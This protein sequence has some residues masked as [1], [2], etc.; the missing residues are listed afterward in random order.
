LDAPLARF[1]P[2]TLVS[3][4]VAT[5]FLAVS[6]VT[7]TVGI[8]GY[9]YQKKHLREL[10]ENEFQTQGRTIAALMLDLFRQAELSGIRRAEYLNTAISQLRLTDPKR[11][12][13]IRIFDE[14]RELVA[15]SDPKDF[16]ALTR[17][18]IRLPN[19]LM[20]TVLYNGEEAVVVLRPLGPATLTWG[21]LEIFYSLE[22]EAVFLKN[23]VASEVQVGLGI[24]ALTLLI[25]WGF[26]R[27]LARPI[28]RLTREVLAVNPEHFTTELVKDRNDEIGI[29]QENFVGLIGRLREAREGERRIQA[30]LIHTSKLAALGTLTAGVAHEIN[31]PITGMQSCLARLQDTVKEPGAARYLDVT[32]R[33]LAHIEKVVRGLLDFTRVK[34]YRFVCAQ[35]APVVEHSLALVS[36]RLK[37]GRIRIVWD[38]AEGGSISGQWDGPQLEQ[39]VVNLLLNAIDALEEKEGGTITIT[40]S[41]NGAQALLAIRDDGPG[42]PA[43]NLSRVFDPFFTT[44][45]PDKGTGLGLSVSDKIIQDHGGTLEVDSPPGGGAVFTLRLPAESAGVPGSAA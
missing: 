32:R 16:L 42:I 18:T 23:F 44:K 14:R 41:R 43:Q 17:L 33:S 12:L 11:I 13:K 6:L 25:S 45:G 38:P 20:E 15:A 1:L 22:Q 2:R 26:A 7:L 39:V 34:S 3:K 8:L 29:L 5:A 31:N 40:A 35:F 19:P 9:R 4:F 10:A 21:Y 36:Y 28:R 27:E 37:D 30:Q 24:L